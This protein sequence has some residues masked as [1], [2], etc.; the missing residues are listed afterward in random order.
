ML[1][2]LAVLALGAL[3]SACATGPRFDTAGVDPDVTP[4]R[5][6]A[7]IE[8]RRGS[9]VVWGGTIIN[10]R[11]FEDSTRI[12][13]LGYPLDAQQ[14]PRSGRSAQGRFLIE[15]PGYL[16]SV[17]YAPGR[18]ITVTGEIRQATRGRIGETEY[19]YPLVAAEQL[20]LW[21]VQ[22]ERERPRVS[23]G[24]GVMMGR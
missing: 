1:R 10:T 14:R 9:P 19:H 2:I 11:N 17:D 4:A 5:A 8:N 23:F 3:L 15:F 12:E 7:E 16:E 6:V 24:V 13:V 20:H 22:A 18:Q 21:P